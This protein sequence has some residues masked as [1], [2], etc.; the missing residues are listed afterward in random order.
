MI[1]EYNKNKYYQDDEIKQAKELATKFYN[2]EYTP[3]LLRIGNKKLGSNVAIW[4]LPS[5]ITCK[6]QCKGCY[7]IKAERMYKNTR[8]MRAFHYEIIKLALVDD[9]KYKYLQSYLNVELRRHAMLYNLPVVRIHSSGDLYSPKYLAFWLELINQNKDIKFYTYTKQLDN[10]LIDTLNKQ[11][12]NF[13][14]VRSLIDNKINF[15]NLDYLEDLS[16]QLDA[17]GEEYHICGYGHEDNKLSCMGNCTK[18]LNCSNI[19]FIK[20]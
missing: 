4:D 17:K 6:Y 2:R 9:V 16:K 20:H 5:I 8:V 12:D 1:K 18:C 10:E 19:L 15:G 7:A 14:I 13:N 3:Q 11:F